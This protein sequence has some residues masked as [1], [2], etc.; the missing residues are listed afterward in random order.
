MI[1][2][3]YERAVMLQ[4]ILSK[5]VLSELSEFPRI[6]LNNIKYVVG[7]DAS[8]RAGE[9]IGVAVLVDYKTEMVLKTSTAVEKPPIPYIPGLLAFREAPVYFK[10]LKKLG[11]EPDV[12]FVNGHGLAHP[13]G[14]GIATHIGLVL[15]KPT[16]GVAR[17]KLFGEEVVIG[18]E[19]YIKAHG[20]IVGKVIEHNNTKLYVSI[21]YR[22]KLEDAVEI[23]MKLMKPNNKLPIPLEVADKISKREARKTK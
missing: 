18:N 10:T 17:R 4:S 7:L 1:E 21:G 15:G 3:S 13:R 12:V 20:H 11:V 22:V 9:I 16:I 8:Y 6:D 19:T 23:T 14:F 2:F 5:K